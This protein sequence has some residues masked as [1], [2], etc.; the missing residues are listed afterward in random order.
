[1][2][3]QAAWQDPISI[4]KLRKLCQRRHKVSLNI[5]PGQ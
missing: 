5:T 3:Q 2:M 1:V 4:E